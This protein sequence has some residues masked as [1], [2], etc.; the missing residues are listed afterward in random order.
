MKQYSQLIMKFQ[1]IIIVLFTI[2]TITNCAVV[3]NDVNSK[4]NQ[5]T[6]VYMKYK[7]GEISKTQMFQSN[8]FLKNDCSL[9]TSRQ[10][11][12]RKLMSGGIKCE[13]RCID[14]KYKCDKT[15]EC[16]HVEHIHDLK[17]SPLS[18]MGHDVNIIGNL[19]MAY[20]MWNVQMGSKGWRIVEIEKSDVYGDIFNISHNNI[21]RCNGVGNWFIVIVIIV[22]ILI[23]VIVFVVDYW[24]KYK[25]RI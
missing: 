15:N 16:W 7:S 11:Y 18:A 17:N 5:H 2:L 25:N 12:I 1:N 24:Y 4:C 10:N 23:A 8:T 14:G 3:C 20:G 13:G 6:S 21:I 19:V 22:F 9:Y